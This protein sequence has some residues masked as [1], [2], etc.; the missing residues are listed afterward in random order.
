[1]S[2]IFIAIVFV[3]GVLYGFTAFIFEMFHGRK[4][5]QFN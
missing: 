2:H 4:T 1:M 3:I 5:K